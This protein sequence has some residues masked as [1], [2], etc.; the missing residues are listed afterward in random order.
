MQKVLT[1]AVALITIAGCASTGLGIERASLPSSLYQLYDRAQIGDKQA[2]FELGV[3]FANGIGVEQDCE[4]ARRLLSLAATD[5]GGTIWV[6][7]PP[8]GNGTQG[9]VIPVNQGPKRYGLST[10][11]ELLD[12]EAFCS[13]DNGV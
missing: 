5:T 6:Y 13:Q 2:Q 12:D 10:A 11:R 1:L 8:V 4:Q 9:R 7:S 3:I